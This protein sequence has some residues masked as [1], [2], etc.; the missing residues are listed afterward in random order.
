MSSVQSE[1]TLFEWFL[2]EGNFASQK[3]IWLPGDIFD[4]LNHGVANGT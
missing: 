3:D 1:I 4:G 2:F